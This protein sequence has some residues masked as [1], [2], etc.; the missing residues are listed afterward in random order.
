[1]T[2][3][4]LFVPVETEK[5]QINFATVSEIFD[6]GITLIFDGEES[7]SEKHYQCNS[8]VVF[9]P[10]DRVR[11]V[12]DSG[13]YIVE[14][15]V[16]NP[17]KSF[18]VDHAKEAYNA[19][20]AEKADTAEKAETAEKAD[21]ATKATN[22]DNA[23]KLNNKT[24]SNLSVKTAENFTGRHTGSRLGFFN[25]SGTAIKAIGELT[26]STSNSTISNKINEIL[27]MLESY[28]LIS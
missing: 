11:V 28:G 14:Y 7:P 12:E 23:S 20:T 18:E 25:R 13:T 3:E 27:R 26:S 2:E 22:A 17:R 19:K 16:G 9:A 8:F 24:E 5:K 6:D 21:T 10:G 1:M 15:P 4:N